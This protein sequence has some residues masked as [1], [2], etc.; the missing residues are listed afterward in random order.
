MNKNDEYIKTI[1]EKISEAWD[2]NV[3]VRIQDL[4]DGSDYSYTQVIEPWVSRMVL[5]YTK[6]ENNILDVGCGCGFLT[7]AIYKLERSNI[8]GIDISSVS[9]EQAKKRYPFIHFVNGDI[10][11]YTSEKKYEIC[12]AVMVLNNMPDLYLFFEKIG[13]LLVENGKII[14]VI[15]HPF[16]WPMKHMRIESFSYTK[17]EAH[18]FHFS[19]KGRTDYNAE[20]TFFHRSLG[21]YINVMHEMGYKIVYCDELMETKEDVLPDILGFVLEKDT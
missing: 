20:V 15:P 13:N 3:G 5:C 16:F 14:M 17:E 6:K 10:Y 11:S 7:N 8:I 19:T 18:Q 12:L 9:V 4:E 2:D 21:K 1:N